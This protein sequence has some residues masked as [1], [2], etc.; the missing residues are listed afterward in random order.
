MFSARW[1]TPADPRDAGRFITD[2]VVPLFAHESYAVVHRTAD[3]LVLRNDRGDTVTIGMA[4]R[5]D[6][7]ETHIWGVA[8]RG[9]RQGLHRI[10]R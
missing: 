8:P 1:R 5:D 9:V 10:S 2:H 6:H 3:E 7:T 4:L